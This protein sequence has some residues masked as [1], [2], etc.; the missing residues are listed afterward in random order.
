MNQKKLAIASDHAGY[1]L[2]RMIIPYLE[3]KGYEVVDLGTDKEDR[4]DYPDFGHKI[5][6]A[7]ANKEFPMGISLCG[8]GNGINMSANK[9]QA[10]RSALCWEPRIAALARAHNNANI[11]ALPARF[12]SYEDAKPILVAFLET[13]FEQGRHSIRVDKIPLKKS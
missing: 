8:S 4:V 6:E 13:G 7:I 3:S 10:I 11:C 9:N 1:H 2:K 12:L 5:A